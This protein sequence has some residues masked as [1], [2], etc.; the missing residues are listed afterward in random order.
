MKVKNKIIITI[1][2]VIGLFVLTAFI[3]KAKAVEL[4]NK[5]QFY[6]I[7]GEF[8]D[9]A[10]TQDGGYVIVG[11][12]NNNDAII[13]K[14]DKEENIE[15]QKEYGGSS[16]DYF[17]AITSLPDGGYIAVGSSHSEDIDGL[18]IENESRADDDAI[19]VKYDKK[20]NI[21]WQKKYGGKNGD[22]YF[23]SVTNTSDGGCIAIGASES[24]D[25]EGITNKGG[26]DAIIVKYDKEGNVKWQKNYGGSD[27]DYFN[28]IT[29][30]P[31]DGYVVVGCSYTIDIEGITNKGGCD[32]IMVKFDE[33]GNLEYQWSYG[34]NGDD[35]F[36]AITCLTDG[37]Y[38]VVGD[39]S[40][41]DIEGITNK[42]RSDAIIVKYSKEGNIDWQKNYID[43]GTANDS[44]YDV[45]CDGEFFV[46]VGNKEEDMGPRSL[47]DDSEKAISGAIIAKYDS[48]GN[49]I[50][51]DLYGADF[52][53]FY[54]V[55]KI[56]FRN[57]YFSWIYQF[58]LEVL[59]IELI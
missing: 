17:D 59:C 51:D 30:L 2:I 35:C 26:Y 28:G 57:L 46:V 29:S 44:F 45:I 34:G 4:D 7:G 20:G 55:L 5:I 9:I 25:L 11:V 27:S 23:I 54:S 13:V 18:A 33:E 52:D 41:T 21:E 53:Y 37:G 40:S 19:I 31:D 50:W 32:A 22:D 56:R 1:F 48:D 42:G 14:Y 16:C 58:I 6:D 3:L 49:L 39:S 10:A 43:S 36:K 8:V 15:W 12:N 38:V 24:T 47:T